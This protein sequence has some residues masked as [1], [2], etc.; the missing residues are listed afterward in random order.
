VGGGDEG[1]SQLLDPR[2]AGLGEGLEELLDVL[3]VLDLQGELDVD[4]PKG[5][6]GKDAIVVNMED[7]GFSFGDD[8]QHSRQPPWTVLDR[9]SQ[10]YESMLLEQRALDDP[11]ED[12]EID[13][14]AAENDH[15]LLAGELGE[16]PIANGAIARCSCSLGQALACFQ[17]LVDSPLDLGLRDELDAGSSTRDATALVAKQL[18][19]AKRDV[20]TIAIA[21][22]KS[23]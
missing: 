12:V 21:L 23:V 17:Q 22:G 9:D 8:G 19:R 6:L 2:I 15:H 14:G 4:L 16:S 20:Y 10:P 11:P 1:N 18:G 3:S 5:C 7:V 13:I